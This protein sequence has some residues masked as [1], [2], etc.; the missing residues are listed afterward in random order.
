MTADIRNRHPQATARHRKE[1]IVVAAQR[2]CRKN[3]TR[4]VEPW[5]LRC[6]FRI[7]PLLNRVRRIQLRLIAF[8]PQPI[9][10]VLGY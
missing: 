3:G 6:F 4:D 5:H 1:V 8:A 2:L 10:D 9:G 7:E